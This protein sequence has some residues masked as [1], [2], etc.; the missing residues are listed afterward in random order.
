MRYLY[1]IALISIVGCD[2]V[3]LPLPALA[4]PEGEW[5]EMPPA[6]EAI[7][8]QAFVNSVFVIDPT[9]AVFSHVLKMNR[10][11]TG[12]VGW[13]GFV[14]LKSRS[15]RYGQSTFYVTLLS[16]KPYLQ[17]LEGSDLGSPGVSC[18]GSIFGD[19]Q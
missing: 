11:I 10:K 3:S 18:R 19:D 7:L 6:D 5:F 4:E 8:K 16:G 14:R 9:S 12:R 15:G 17:S 2:N 1:L 13:C